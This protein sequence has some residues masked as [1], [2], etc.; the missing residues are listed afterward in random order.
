MSVAQ[1]S[2][3]R[4]YASGRGV[5]RDLAE[6]AGWYRKAADQGL[7]PAMYQLSLAY[8]SG[9]GVSQD[10]V[11]AYEWMDLALYR[12]RGGLRNAYSTALNALAAKT[13]PKDITEARR[14]VEA[15][16]AKRSSPTR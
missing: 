9:A 14:L 8:S 5:T 15:W 12:A 3:G 6:A 1:L 7:A 4:L 11:A 16:K 10:R 13:T 2:L